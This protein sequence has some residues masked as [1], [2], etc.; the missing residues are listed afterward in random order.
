MNEVND[1]VWDMVIH[2]VWPVL[3]YVLLQI[4]LI[5]RFSGHEGIS[6]L[7]LAIFA[8]QFFG[9]WTVFYSTLLRDMGFPSRAALLLV[10]SAL[11][12]WLASLALWSDGRSAPTAGLRFLLAAQFL[13]VAPAWVL[14]F[15][16]WRRLKRLCT[17]AL[18]EEQAR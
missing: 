10:A 3:L 4:L 1:R 9:A 6:G 16:R 18:A 7:S 5:S 11:A 14:T 17:E 13:P 2:M 8:A 15:G 12:G